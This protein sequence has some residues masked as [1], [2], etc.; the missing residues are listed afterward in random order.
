M[1]YSSM[2]FLNHRRGLA[3][4]TILVADYLSFAI[5]SHLNLKQTAQNTAD[6]D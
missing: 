5:W 3:T 1:Y 6:S 4:P 2:K